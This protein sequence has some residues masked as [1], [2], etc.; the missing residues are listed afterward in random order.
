MYNTTSQFIASA[1]TLKRALL[2][3]LLVNESLRI[4]TG[5]AGSVPCVIDKPNRII[6][7]GGYALQMVPADVNAPPER[8]LAR[9]VIGNRIPVITNYD[10]PEA[11]A[12]AIGRECV[13]L[14]IRSDSVPQLPF[15]MRERAGI[16]I[17][18]GISP[19]GVVELLNYVM[20][21]H[22][23]EDARF[24]ALRAAAG[25]GFRTG[26][27]FKDDI[28]ALVRSTQAGTDEHQARVKAGLDASFG[29]G[30]SG[31]AMRGLLAICCGDAAVR[32]CTEFAKEDVLRLVQP[33]FAHRIQ[34]EDAELS[35]KRHAIHDLPKIAD[36]AVKA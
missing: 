7:N 32:G 34:F 1:R 30:V 11:Q 21:D 10:S 13:M 24:I 5:S 3:C 33:S 6:L 26:A 9:P 27:R 15:S 14:D 35:V 22:D 16:S 36:W 17:S 20:E 29:L 12:K 28:C 19:D 18:I 4:E 2:T 31:H 8:F 25:T 23:F